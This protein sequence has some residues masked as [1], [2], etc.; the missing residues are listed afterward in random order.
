MYLQRSN[1]ASNRLS[2]EWFS[3]LYWYPKLSSIDKLSLGWVNGKPFCGIVTS[4]L[5]STLMVVFT[6]WP[7]WSRETNAFAILENKWLPVLQSTVGQH[8]RWMVTP[9][10]LC[11]VFQG[12]IT[13]MTSCLLSCTPVSFWKGFHYKRKEFAPSRNLFFL[14]KWTPF[15][16]AY[17][18]FRREKMIFTVAFLKVYSF[19]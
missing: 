18:L 15:L 8:L 16:L 19:P 4:D 7:W 17:T 2:L 3:F 13:F 5:Q 14:L 6:W 9:G 10:R 11:A 12:V 1:I